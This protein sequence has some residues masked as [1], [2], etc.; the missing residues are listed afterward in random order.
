M[1]EKTWISKTPFGP[2]RIWAKL[3][4]VVSKWA[5]FP[6]SIRI[7]ILRSGGVK[8]GKECFIGAGV[9]FDTLFP[10]LIEIGDRCVIT[11][12]AHILSHFYNTTDRK[13]YAGKVTIGNDVFIG[14]NSLIINS[15]NIGDSVTIG[16]ASVIN[17][18]VPA[19][20]LWAGNPA[21]FIKKQNE[22]DT[23]IHTR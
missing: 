1:N 13:F 22:T 16:A 3:C 12:G 19:N 18:D 11:S 5:C 9:H 6:T 15:V 14:L 23:K 21:T 10:N 2:K 20:E 8:I 4:M 17:R 7:R